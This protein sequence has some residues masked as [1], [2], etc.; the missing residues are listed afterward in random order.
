MPNFGRDLT[1]IL[2]KAVKKSGHVFAHSVQSPVASR[3]FFTNFPHK[4]L[5]AR[6]S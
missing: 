4:Q 5:A 3:L 2:Q 6:H 1:N